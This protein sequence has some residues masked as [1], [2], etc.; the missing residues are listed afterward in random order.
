ML[1]FFLV[2][3]R[4]FVL[5]TCDPA[6]YLDAYNFIK[7]ALYRKLTRLFG[8][9]SDVKR[10]SDPALM[11]RIQDFADAAGSGLALK[12]DELLEQIK[13]HHPEQ[14]AWIQDLIRK[15][16]PLTVVNMPAATA[17]A[18]LL[19][20][21]LQKVSRRML[22]IELNCLGSIPFDREVQQSALDLVPHVARHPEGSLASFFKRILP[23][24]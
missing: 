16:R 2:A 22:A 24:L 13:I 23:E 6:S 12:I 15:F 3:N 19:A 10:P 7:M 14:H 20:E 21:R 9:E 5:T 4:C 8:P 11:R 1:D 17:D 18:A